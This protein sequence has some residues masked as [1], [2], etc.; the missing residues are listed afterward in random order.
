M[1]WRCDKA[2]EI[3]MKMLNSIIL[4]ESEESDLLR[5]LREKNR[6]ELY[7]S[8]DFTL[9]KELYSY[10]SLFSSLFDKLESSK[11]P[12]LQNVIATYYLI[13]K[14]SQPSSI[15]TIHLATF[16]E[17]IIICLNNNYLLQ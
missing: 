17:K 8:I 2:L 11:T 15:D 1:Q 13:V 5:I 14:K 7:I 4:N 10:L 3:I 16:K 6:K 12:T 9:I